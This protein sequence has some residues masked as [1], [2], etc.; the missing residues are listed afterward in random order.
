MRLGNHNWADQN[1]KRGTEG[2]KQKKIRGKQTQN[3]KK[4]CRQRKEESVK[5]MEEELKEKENKRSEK[6]EISG[7][8]EENLKSQKGRGMWRKREGERR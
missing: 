8:E 4:T 6:N 2:E 7:G 1:R 3:K 5:K